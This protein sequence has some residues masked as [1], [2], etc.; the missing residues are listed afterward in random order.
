MK[1]AIIKKK[2]L[3]TIAIVLVSIALGCFL[4]TSASKRVS[5][6]PSIGKTVVID[7]GHGGMDGGVLG[8]T[9]GVK[10]SEI[11]LA[12]AK[13]LKHFFERGG[14]DVVMTRSNNDGLYDTNAK[15]KKLSDMQTRRDI[16]NKA[17]P[18]L[19]IS[20]HQNYYPLSSVKGAQV[21][22]SE[23]NESSKQ[24]AQSM[25]NYLNGSLG[26]ERIAKSG[27]YYILTCTEYPAVIAECGFLS[28][29]DEERKL[30][31]AEYQERIAYAIYSATQSYLMEGS[32]AN[33]VT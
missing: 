8:K 9:T 23:S 32:N 5:Y 27:D 17:Q 26:N 10:E 4:L 33:E 7:A 19:V 31:K 21:F 14:Y 20:V 30:V 13:S 18:D 6:V 15:N 3:L 16:I 25:Q 1:I 29:V 12:I 11:N 2:S 28:N 22:Y 24:I